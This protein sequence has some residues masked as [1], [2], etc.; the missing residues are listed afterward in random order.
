MKL[1]PLRVLLVLQ[2]RATGNSL[3]PN[4]KTLNF[5]AIDEEF[6]SF[7]PLF[8]SRTTTLVNFGSFGSN[9]SQEALA[10]MIAALPKLCPGLRE[11]RF[12]T[13]PKNPIISTA[14]SE[15]LLTT[16]QNTLHCFH[17]D[18][19]L[20]DEARE[21][22]CK[23]PNLRDL[24]MFIDGPTSLPS[25][26]LPGLAKIYIEYGRDNNWLEGFRGASLGKLASAT[27]SPKY[28]PT[29]DFLKALESVVLT[30]SIPLTL[31]SLKLRTFRPW[32][33]NYRSLLPF[34]QLKTLSIESP[35]TFVCTSTIDDNTITDLAQTMPQLE[36]L[37]LGDPPCNTPAG[38][39]LKGLFTL[40]RC[41][42]HLSRLCIHFQVTAV[43]PTAIPGQNFTNGSTSPRESCALTYLQAGAIPVPEESASMVALVLLRIFPHLTEIDYTYRGWKKVVGAICDSRGLSSR[44]SKTS[45][46]CFAMFI[47]SLQD[48]RP[49]LRVLSNYEPRRSA[50]AL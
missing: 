3:L 28:A 41:C 49:Y 46:R 44:V 33:P 27:F 16:N 10:S 31:S 13:L 17:A 25:M 5:W 29:D 34:T 38:I 4:L 21:V 45:R 20:T 15:L 19:P 9:P 48:Q 37:Q 24:R 1:F 12:N 39:T 6:I 23:L 42:P 47:T 40:A 2:S 11:I 43:D 32:I 22:I 7:I 14:V 30:T 35:C 26:V 50:R 36:S 8:L 18:S